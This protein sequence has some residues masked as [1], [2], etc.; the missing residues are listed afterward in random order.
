MA[1]PLLTVEAAAQHLGC[2][3]ETIR[4]AI[5]TRK[6]ACYRLSGCIRIAPDHLTAYLESNL[7]PAQGQTA[8]R[9]SNT[10]ASGSSSGT[11]TEERVAA[12]QQARRIKSA[13]N[14]PTG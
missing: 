5:R 9:S 10:A 7:C 3:P 4:R 6:L 14:K 11:T 13:V 1:D 2:H 12:F 8:P